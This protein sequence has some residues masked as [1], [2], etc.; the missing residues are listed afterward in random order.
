MCDRGCQRSSSWPRAFQAATLAGPQAISYQS[1][2]VFLVAAH[3]P[4][5]TTSTS[6]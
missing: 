6:V 2:L 3:N 5:F 1:L 4:T